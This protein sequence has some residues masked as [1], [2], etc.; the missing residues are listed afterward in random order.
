MN[1][2][3]QG[4]S[5][6]YDIRSTDGGTTW[7]IPKLVMVISANFLPSPS[8]AVSGSNVYVAYRECRHVPSDNGEIHMK[9]SP[10]NGTTWLSFCRLTTDTAYSWYPSVA[11]SDTLVHVVWADSRDHSG[12]SP[13]T[14]IYYKHYR[15]GSGRFP[16]HL[17]IPSQGRH[18]VRD[19][20]SRSM[21]HL[22]MQGEDKMIYYTRSSDNGSTWVVPET[23]G[24]GLNPSVGLAQLPEDV[25]PYYYA[26][27]VAYSDT[28]NYQLIY[29]WNDGYDDPGTGDWD[30]DTLTPAAYPLG[31]PALT[32]FNTRVYVTYAAN[33]YL[34]CDNFE[35]NLPDSF[36]RQTLDNSGS[37]SQPSM[38]YDGQWTVHAA[39]K[40]GSQVYY[41]ARD[42]NGNWPDSMKLRVDYS[43]DSSQ[44]PF[45]ECYGDSAFV[46]WADS[47]PFEIR[48]A[49]KDLPYLGWRVWRNISISSNIASE[50]PTQAWQEFVNWA[51]GR[52]TQGMFDIKYWRSTGDTG[53]VE[54]NPTL[55]S[56]WPHVVKWDSWFWGTY[57]FTAWT[58][59]PTP[60]QPPYTVMT[61]LPFGGGF[62]GSGSG[63]LTGSPEYG[64]Y[65][66]VQAGQDAPS[67][68][69]RKRDGVMKFEGK[70][71]DFARD[72]LVYE[73]RY[74]DPKYD[75]L[76]KVSSYREEGVNWTQGLSVDGRAVKSV[77]FASN[78]VDT[79]WFKIPPVVYANDHRA[80]FALKNV[81]GDYVTNLGLTLYQRDPWRSGKGGPQV[82][83]PVDP[84]YRE[85][86]AVY[87]NPSKGEAQV[88]YS[89]RVPGKV[90]LSIYDVT[91]RMVRKLVDGSQPAGVHKVTWD[92]KDALGRK[93][94]NGIYFVRLS[95]PERVKTV[96]AVVLR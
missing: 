7:E 71:V 28:N 83:A 26:L 8:V 84:V 58:E 6:I 91:G 38:A 59:S 86:F 18:V 27:C 85:V 30:R 12:W 24:L 2:T 25:Y 90:D 54:P 4:D 15:S 52:P 33:S 55:W 89:L 74:L 61:K 32:A 44:H 93:V 94:S 43:A 39:W 3:N 29:Q 49:S 21:L 77:K 70:A 14:D 16:G 79:A 48:R 62:G 36:Q 13:P 72:S 22:V 87:P 95:S 20:T 65:Y 75:Y 5:D 82:G 88:V 68:Y 17:T 92:S 80:A 19:P 41:C 37:A 10:D 81:K 56:Y 42:A 51:E 78:K 67:P 69:C 31:A 11:A 40:R 46:V 53:I 47:T 45:V 1:D 50:S 23:L 9:Y 35:Y 63:F 73:F 66:Q 57:L 64:I 34:Y 96:K 76:V 60:N